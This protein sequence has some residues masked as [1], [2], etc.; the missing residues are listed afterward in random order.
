MVKN[1]ILF[2]EKL[3]KSP[4]FR[5]TLLAA[6]IVSTIVRTQKALIVV[7]NSSFSI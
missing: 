5:Q 4:L 7:C 2:T 1:F 6:L 3:E